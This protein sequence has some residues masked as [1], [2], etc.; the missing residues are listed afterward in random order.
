LALR[1][2]ADD[3]AGVVLDVADL[4][5]WR[6]GGGTRTID[7]GSANSTAVG[8]LAAQLTH[9][10][11]YTKTFSGLT[12]AK[13][14]RLHGWYSV[15]VYTPTSGTEHKYQ[16]RMVLAGSTHGYSLGEVDVT[17][18]MVSG[19]GVQEFTGVTSTDMKVTL[20]SYA[21]DPADGRY[22]FRSFSWRLEE[23]YV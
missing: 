5:S 7:E 2:A 21:A 4:V 15:S 17:Y 11:I 3:L 19:S 23:V 14:Y 16:G 12:A 18:G 10:T 8:T 22:Y 1:K 6:S 9:E 20:Y 13:T